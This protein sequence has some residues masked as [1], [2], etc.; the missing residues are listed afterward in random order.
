VKGGGH[1]ANPGFSSTPGVQISLARFDKIKAKSTTGTVKLGP[2]LT[3]DQVYAALDPTGVNAIGGRIPGVGV[4]GVTLGGGKC[5]SSPDASM[6]RRSVIMC[7]VF[8]LKQRVRPF[9]RQRCELRSCPTQWNYHV[10]HFEKCGS[11]VRA[12]SRL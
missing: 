7:K 2:G 3:W 11:L 9:G 1:T 8:I 12:E 6:G 5:R 10:G 4:A